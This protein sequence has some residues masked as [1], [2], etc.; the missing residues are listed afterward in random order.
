[1]LSYFNLFIIFYIYISDLI[2]ADRYICT[3]SKSRDY[4][5]EWEINAWNDELIHCVI[6][7]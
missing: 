2:S 7:I 5:I 4:L 1:M 3:I 6:I